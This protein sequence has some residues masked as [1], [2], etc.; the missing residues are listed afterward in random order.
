M[1]PT[2]RFFL[3]D[4]PTFPNHSSLFSKKRVGLLNQI[5]MVLQKH[6]W[7]QLCVWSKHVPYVKYSTHISFL[8]F[9][10]WSK[11]CLGLVSVFKHHPWYLNTYFYFCGLT[12][13]LQNQMPWMLKVAVRHCHCV[14]SRMKS[15]LGSWLFSPEN[16]EHVRALKNKR[17]KLRWLS[18]I[19]CELLIP[20][21]D[22][23]FIHAHM[24]LFL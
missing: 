22:I 6:H 18:F 19:Y 23:C 14:S 11:V 7:F 4:I 12:E 5:W 10:L 2:S 13:T 9:F 15:V 3:S 1:V 20:R 21:E 8:N 16:Q 17:L 24:I